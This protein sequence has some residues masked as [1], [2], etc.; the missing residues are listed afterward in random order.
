MKICEWGRQTHFV[1]NKSPIT[2][3]T[4]DMI[5]HN[6]TIHKATNPNWDIPIQVSGSIQLLTYLG[7]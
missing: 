7:R 6:K 4:P 5:G 2:V 3:A 1:L